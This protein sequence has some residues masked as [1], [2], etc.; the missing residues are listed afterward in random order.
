MTS[1]PPLNNGVTVA[2][3]DF[4]GAGPVRDLISISFKVSS[5]PARRSVA[6][7]DARRAGMARRLT[8]ERLRCCGLAALADDAELIVS[9]LVTNAIQHSGATE[10]HLCVIVM[11]EALR[12]HVRDGMPG[13]GTLRRP[14]DT[15]ESG[16]GLL[17]VDALVRASGGDWGTSGD[18]AETWCRLPVPEGGQP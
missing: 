16:R 17:L 12:L 11:A 2:V 5:D 9:E 8:A 10:I 18:G 3:D 15:A 6:A 7:C 13:T 14:Q 4:G 1:A